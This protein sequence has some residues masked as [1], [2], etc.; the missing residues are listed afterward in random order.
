M[1]VSTE[2]PQA[3]LRWDWRLGLRP[4]GRGEAEGPRAWSGAGRLLGAQSVAPG[5]EGL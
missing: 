4:L 5:S 3:L 1:V 2:V